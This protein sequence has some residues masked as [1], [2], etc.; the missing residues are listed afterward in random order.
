MIALFGAVAE[1][2]TT[3]ELTLD[4]ARTLAMRALL[5][6]EDGA[7]TQIANGLLQ[8]NPNDRAALIIMAAAAPRQGN[9]VEGRKA[10]AR[11]WRLSQTDTEKYEAARLT[12]LAAASEE[13]YTLADMARD[14]MAV[15]DAAGRERATWSRFP[16]TST[17]SSRV[18]RRY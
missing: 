14:S 4:D 5:A 2:Q 9:P 11:A 17:G 13:R 10:G 1:A 18:R 16:P 12:A 3:V 6:G 15:L 8:A 7:A